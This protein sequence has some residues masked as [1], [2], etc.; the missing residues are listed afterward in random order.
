MFKGGHRCTQYPRNPK[1]VHKVSYDTARKGNNYERVG[2][3]LNR[4]LQLCIMY[5]V[6]TSTYP[7]NLKLE[8]LLSVLWRNSDFR[9][10]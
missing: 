3:K 4:L 6:G 5:L 2:L 8:L 7:I 10:L 1:E 9:V